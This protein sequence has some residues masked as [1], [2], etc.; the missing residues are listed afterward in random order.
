[1]LK[2]VVTTDP[3]IKRKRLLAPEGMTEQKIDMILSRKTPH[4]EKRRRADNLI[5]TS[6]SNATTSERGI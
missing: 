3:Q 1:D 2:D 4:E 6:H 5:D